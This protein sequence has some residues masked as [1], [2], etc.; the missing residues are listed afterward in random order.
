[1]DA[2]ANAS[3][4]KYLCSKCRKI[5]KK[6]ERS[7]I[8]ILNPLDE[9]EFFCGE[10]VEVIKGDNATTIPDEHKYRCSVCTTEKD[11]IK[12]IP[13]KVANNVREMGTLC[14]NYF[15][16]TFRPKKKKCHR[17]NEISIKSLITKG[18]FCFFKKRYD[19]SQI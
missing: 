16:L 4:E 9:E 17:I 6:G 11:K 10:C 1:M 13:V 3:K 7:P 2:K 12:D 5:H 19:S 15:N 14:T 8:T 18:S